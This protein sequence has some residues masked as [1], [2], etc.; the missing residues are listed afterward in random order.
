M[1]QHQQTPDEVFDKVLEGVLMGLP[2]DKACYLAG[3]NPSTFYK[4][5]QRNEDLFMRWQ[6]ADAQAYIIFLNE[7]RAGGKGSS[8]TMTYL[9]RRWSKDLPN[10]DKREVH[11][12]HEMISNAKETK[13]IAKVIREDKKALAGSIDN[14]PGTAKEANAN[15]KNVTPANKDKT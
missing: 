6:A 13:A 1:A 11:H 7:A 15:I 10:F 14:L 5:A 9:L 12:T 8:A 4:N 2:L 3:I